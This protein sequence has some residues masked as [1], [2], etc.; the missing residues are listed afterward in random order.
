MIHRE[1]L[2]EKGLALAI[3]PT[4]DEI[5]INMRGSGIII[6]TGSIFIGT[7]VERLVRNAGINTLIFTGIDTDLGIESLL[8]FHQVF[9][10]FIIIA[11]FQLLLL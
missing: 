5:V 10:C 1:I 8:L 4:R 3:W 2:S 6:D 11:H 7:E 9:S